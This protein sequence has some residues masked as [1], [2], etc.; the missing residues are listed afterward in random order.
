MENEKWTISEAGQKICYY[1]SAGGSADFP[2]PYLCQIGCCSHG[3]CTVA[4]LA[5]RSNS[6]GWAIAL[7]SVVLV[8]II[9][10]VVAMFTVYLMNRRKD[11]VLKHHIVYGGGSSAASQVRWNS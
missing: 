9:L 11:K 1:R 7:L 5:A 4:D 2:I 6:F 3:C 8:T 10:A